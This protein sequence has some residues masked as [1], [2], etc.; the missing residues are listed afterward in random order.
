MS[1]LWLGDANAVN[2]TVRLDQGLT[3]VWNGAELH[4]RLTTVFLNAAPCLTALTPSVL[5]PVFLDPGTIL[6]STVTR[7]KGHSRYHFVENWLQ[8][9]S[10]PDCG[11][12]I[13]QR[14]WVTEDRTRHEWTNAF[15]LRY[16]S[17]KILLKV[18]SAATAHLT[19]PF[20]TRG[21]Y[22]GTELSE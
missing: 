9:S 11:I 21:F 19:Y 10:I 5:Y 18:T 12:C 1:F 13:P 22:P 7:V 3:L 15:S 8:D 6:T 16:C 14:Y 20:E 4:I 17:Q 2:G